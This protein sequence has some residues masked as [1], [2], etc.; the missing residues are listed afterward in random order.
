MVFLGV[1]YFVQQR[2]V[3]ARTVSPTMSAGQQKIMQYL[4]VVFA[5]FQLF[6]PVGLVIYYITQT[7]LRIGQQ[8]YITQRFYG[9]DHSLGRQAQAAG[10]EAR[11]LA[12][13]DKAA[14]PTAVGPASRGRQARTGQERSQG[15]GE[16]GADR[17]ARRR[18][19]P[20]RR[21]PAEG[22]RSRRRQ[23]DSG[24]EPQAR[25]ARTGIRQPK[26]P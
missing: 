14:R 18:R 5:V 6:F 26:K 1:L 4:P 3:A 22:G 16:A 11:E 25:R 24:P 19:R 7:L 20:G 17:S 10:A 12:K 9:G 23:P 8:Y 21:R 13:N 15:A 2:M